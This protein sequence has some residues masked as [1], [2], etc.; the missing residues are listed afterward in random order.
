MG[1]IQDSYDENNPTPQGSSQTPVAAPVPA[2]S[3]SAA[4][5]SIQGSFDNKNPT[6][7]T[8]DTQLQDL[9]PWEKPADVSWTDYAYAKAR[10]MGSALGN[11]GEDV[12]KVYA[13]DATI[14]LGTSGL[15]A[16]QGQ[17]TADY[18]AEVQAARDRIGASQYGIDAMAF[19]TSPFR[20]LGAGAK[21]EQVAQASIDRVAPGL[22]AKVAKRIGDF[23]EGGTYTGAQSA[24]HGDDPTTVA[25]N[26][27]G[28][29]L[30]SAGFGGISQEIAPWA[31]WVR[32][33]VYGTPEGS[34]SEIA[35]GPPAGAP[36]TTPA[37][38]MTRDMDANQLNLWNS[39]AKYGMPPSQPEV[40]GYAS[41]VY[42][43][44]PAKWPAALRDLH[45]AAGEQGGPSTAKKV[46]LQVGANAA[47]AGAQ[48]VGLGFSPEVSAIVHPAV[49]AATDA[50]MPMLGRGFS[51]DP[52]K[53]ALSDAYPALTGWRN[54]P[55]TP[56]W[57][58]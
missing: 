15:A 46:A 45:E 5:N 40:R 43:D 26:A 8:T 22:T 23:V 11:A 19:M 28:G 33:K 25:E 3:Q 47:A 2:P 13:D 49:T 20:W 41:K 50:V 24:G 31:K 1:A 4:P 48:Y 10:K 51:A 54:A 29:G 9:N 38:A 58:Y 57:R 6:P 55:N 30:F 36:Q 44:D 42:G 17:N 21:A 7:T 34:P 16:S 35:A 39:Q 53:G 56:S 32:G 37:A 52:F 18:R 12:G 14:G 27:A